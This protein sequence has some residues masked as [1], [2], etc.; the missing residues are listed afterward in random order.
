MRFAAEWISTSCLGLGRTLR[1][2]GPLPGA[3][4]GMLSPRAGVQRVSARL[5]A[6]PLPAAWLSRGCK[7]DIGRAKRH[8]YR[9]YQGRV[10]R[11]CVECWS[12]DVVVERDKY[13]A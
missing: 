1:K 5:C 11:D 6:P 2:R 12:I 13:R 8:R 10:L 4:V 7:V 3:R 9:G